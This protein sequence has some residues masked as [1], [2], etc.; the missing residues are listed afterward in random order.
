[1]PPANACADATNLTVHEPNGTCNQGQ[2]E[3][4]S[5]LVPCP[6]GCTG[7][8]CD[9]DPCIGVSCVSPPANSCA[10]ATHLL[11]YE[12]PGVCN[13]GSC[14][15][16]S[17]QELCASGCSGGACNGGC[18]LPTDACTTGTQDRKGCTNARVIGRAVA[19]T[20]AGYTASPTNCTSSNLMDS[21]SCSD[22]GND[23]TYR[24]FLRQGETMTVT[25]STGAE[26]LGS[27]WYAT[28][29][30]YTNA[31]CTSTQC[32]TTVLCDQDKSN[33]TKTHVAAQD[34]WY[35]VVVDGSSGNAGVYT[36]NVKLTCNAG[37]CE[38]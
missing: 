33:T 29:K 12:S 22:S 5:S 26:C 6:N 24:L 18:S 32:S 16:G 30:F 27:T 10:D 4:A 34:G 31:G 28:L 19:G 7:G 8:A 2:C 1:M 25:L 9:G 15:Y 37:N 38:C 36:V 14:E 21:A 20:P 35:I 11:V 23:H 13:A 3:Y 17:H